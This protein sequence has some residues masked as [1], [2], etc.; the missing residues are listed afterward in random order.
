MIFGRILRT[1]SKLQNVIETYVRAL[2]SPYFL[3]HAW[4][5]VASSLLINQASVNM[6]IMNKFRCASVQIYAMLN[7]SAQYEWHIP[8]TSSTLRHA[9]HA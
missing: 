7:Y 4:L 3:P 1:L 9:Q 5:I 8:R 2:S 6:L